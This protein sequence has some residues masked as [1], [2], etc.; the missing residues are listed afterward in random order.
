MSQKEH[1]CCKAVQTIHVPLQGMGEI[2]E[3]VREKGIVTGAEQSNLWKPRFL[4][5]FAT[6]PLTFPELEAIMIFV[7]TNQL[8]K[9]GEAQFMGKKEKMIRRLLA[10]P[11]DYT[12]SEAIALSASFGYQERNKGSTSGSRVM[13]FRESDRKKILLHKPHPGDIMK[14]YAVKQLLQHFVENGDINE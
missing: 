8:Q 9:G 7:T 2:Q 1:P 11:S 13:L 3:I 12:Y 4:G 14:P 5:K 10:C 6:R